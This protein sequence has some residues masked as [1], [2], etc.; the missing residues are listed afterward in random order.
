MPTP[1]MLSVRNERGME[2]I[3]EPFGHELYNRQQSMSCSLSA[4]VACP[5]CYTYPSSCTLVGP[6]TRAW[7]KSKAKKD[8]QCL[9]ACMGLKREVPHFK[10]GLTS[11]LGQTRTTAKVLNCKENVYGRGGQRCAR[12]LVMGRGRPGAA[13]NNGGHGS[14][15][16]TWAGSG[17][18]K[19]QG[20]ETA[21]TEAGCSNRK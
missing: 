17:D 10:C 14:V 1:Y 15:H 4:W 11:K 13:E 9:H 8:Q 3:C 16:R 18:Q 20:P 12:G 21:G 2:S 5:A 19:P 7:N 6:T